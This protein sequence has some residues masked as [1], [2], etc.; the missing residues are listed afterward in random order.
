LAENISHKN[1]EIPVSRVTLPTLH[2]PFLS[3]LGT[4]IATRHHRGPAVTS[5]TCAQGS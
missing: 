1:A 4:R 2:S 5:A 3:K